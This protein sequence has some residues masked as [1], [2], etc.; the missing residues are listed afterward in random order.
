MQDSSQTRRCRPNAKVCSFIRFAVVNL[1]LHLT[2]LG[3]SWTTP[4][5]DEELNLPR[6]LGLN[7]TAEYDDICFYGSTRFSLTKNATKAFAMNLVTVLR[8]IALRSYNE[9]LTGKGKIRVHIPITKAYESYF[10]SL[11]GSLDGY[12]KL[13]VDFSESAH[14]HAA[15]AFRTTT[16]QW[17]VIVKLDADDVLFP[18]YLDWIVQKVIPTLD[19]GALVT[20]REL[21]VLSCGFNRCMSEYIAMNFFGGM[22]VGQ[23]RVFRRDVFEALGM[24]FESP[25]HTSCWFVFRRAVFEHILKVK[26]PAVLRRPVPPEV[27]RNFSLQE[28]MDSDLEKATGIRTVETTS[29]GFGPAGIYLRTPLSGHFEYDKILTRTQ[30]CT[31]QE[32]SRVI[33]DATRSNVMKSKMA[34]VRNVIFA[35]NMTLF[36]TCKSH[37]YFEIDWF[38]KHT[39]EEMEA[40]MRKALAKAATIQVT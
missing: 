30:E 21:P 31:P 11:L 37:K 27:W 17:V 20:S 26:P 8:D 5:H 7:L 32:W 34:Y 38:D 24:P 33:T 3:K 15:N 2:L 28:S 9:A 36:D 25:T 40:S 22:S 35:A 12:D 29:S 39:C 14:Q 23:T 6:K 10:H 4:L 19:R 16:C 18:G 13:Q 1:A